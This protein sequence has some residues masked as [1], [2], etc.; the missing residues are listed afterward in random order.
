MGSAADRPRVLSPVHRQPC[1]SQMAEARAPRECDRRLLRRHPPQGLNPFAV[2]AMAERGSTSRVTSQGRGRVGSHPVRLRRDRVRFAV[3][4][5]PGLPPVARASFMPGSMTRPGLA[6]GAKTDDEAMPHYR[7][8]RDEIRNIH[9]NA[10]PISF[11]RL[12]DE[13]PPCCRRFL[14]PPLPLP[15]GSHS[16]SCPRRSTPMPC[17]S[18]PRGLA[19]RAGADA[20]GPVGGGCCSATAGHSRPT[21]S[22][23]RSATPRANPDAVP[24]GQHG[25]L[26]RQPNRHR[27]LRPRRGRARPSAGGG[28]TAS[29]PAPRSAKSG[30][31]IGVDMTPDM[32]NKARAETS[33]PIARPGSTTSSSAS[34]E[35]E[36]LP[37]PTRAS[38]VVISNCVLNL[39]SRQAPRRGRDRPV[40]EAGGRVAVSDL[41]WSARPTV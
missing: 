41:A 31:V 34:G 33:R 28:L 7:R 20:V 22:P 10:A 13:Q 38:T 39:F 2:R 18:C 24:G 3:R 30:R 17:A 19:Q 9:R 29:L 37:S 12:Q 4:G 14:L 27:L 16:H 8:V 23:R 25:P 15:S 21:N 35:I 40:L 32:L 11:G 1:R 6:S 36:S 5:V 26:L